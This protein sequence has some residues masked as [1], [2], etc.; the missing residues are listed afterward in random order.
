MSFWKLVTVV[1]WGFS[2]GSMFGNFFTIYLMAGSRSFSERQAGLA[3]LPSAH[4]CRGQHGREG[5]WWKCGC[6]VVGAQ[7]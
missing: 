5:M 3:L 1:T 6:D 2:L 7:V 4:V